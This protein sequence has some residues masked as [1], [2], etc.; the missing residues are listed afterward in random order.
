DDGKRAVV[1]VFFNYGKPDPVLTMLKPELDKLAKEPCQR[2]ERKVDIPMFD[3]SFLKRRPRKYYRYPGSLTTPPC[4]ENVIWNVLSEVETI[5]K[6]QVE[7][8]KAPL[9][10][11]YKIKNARPTQ[12][13][14]GRKVQTYDGN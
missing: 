11:A 1:G 3:S 2:K 4:D 13:L 14:N 8:L 6:D 10:E 12:P 7:A 5:S 9:R